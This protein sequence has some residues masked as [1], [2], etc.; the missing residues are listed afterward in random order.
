MPMDN[1]MAYLAGGAESPGL[2]DTLG[3]IGF[4]VQTPHFSISGGDPQ[5]LRKKRLM[6][7]MQNMMRTPGATVVPTMQSSSAVN[8]LLPRPGMSMNPLIQTMRQPPLFAPW[9]LPPSMGGVG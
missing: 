1:P 9:S 3:S 2:L 6:A 8:P 4:Q 7:M 5:L